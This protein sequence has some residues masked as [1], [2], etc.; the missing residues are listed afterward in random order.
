MFAWNFIMALAR[1]FLK[2]EQHC[3]VN[4]TCEGKETRPKKKQLTLLRRSSNIMANVFPLL[5][6]RFFC[7]II[8][9]LVMPFFFWI[10][11]SPMKNLCGNDNVVSV[12]VTTSTGYSSR[13]ESNSW[14]VQRVILIWSISE[15]H[16]TQCLH[17]L[18]TFAQSLCYFQ[19]TNGMLHIR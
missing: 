17:Y 9:T 18:E 11:S 7:S 15:F 12:Q 6:I 5:S 10:H 2:Y 19:A 4:V 8:S 16:N 13:R 3:H 14:H 1:V